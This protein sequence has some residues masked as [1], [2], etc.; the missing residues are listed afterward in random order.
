M[1]RIFVVL[2]FISFFGCVFAQQM[3]DTELKNKL[4]KEGF[5]RFTFFDN[6]EYKYHYKEMSESLDFSGKYKI[7]S[8]IVI[9]ETITN[10]KNNG[11][12]DDA[13]NYSLGI[14]GKYKIDNEKKNADYQGALVGIDNDKIYWSNKAISA[15]DHTV[16]DGVECILYPQDEENKKY[17]LLLENLKIRKQPSTKAEVLTINGYESDVGS[18]Y[19]KRNVEFAGSVLWVKAKSVKEDAIDGKSSPWYYIIC[20]DE[21]NN[22]D[23]WNYFG[24]IYGGYVKEI[25]QNEVEK[26]KNEYKPLLIKKLK[27][28]GAKLN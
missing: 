6:D 23:G 9:F 4:V 2:L 26:Y 16:I 8:G 14:P 22:F 5:G 19:E 27:E 11:Y 3:N 17:V 7:D 1:K 10:L 12:Y 15:Y 18:I 20:S 21:I 25:E 28:A 13:T 24:W